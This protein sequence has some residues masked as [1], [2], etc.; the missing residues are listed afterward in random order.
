[1]PSNEYKSSG[2][3]MV[4]LEGKLTRDPE[5]RYLQS[6]MAICKLSMANNQRYKTKSGESK[7]D[8][9]FVN[10]TVWAKSAEYCGEHFKKGYPVEVVGK[11]KMEEWEDK[12]TGA[13]RSTITITADDR[14]YQKTWDNANAGGGNQGGGNHGG[15]ENQPKPRVIEE[16]MQESD[17]LPF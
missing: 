8:T 5:L 13:K 16:P 15:Y 11:L 6:G 2:M 17:D 7:E 10:V 9:L 12:A 14:I 4:I 1:M 3:N